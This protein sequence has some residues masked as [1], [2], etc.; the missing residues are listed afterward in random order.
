MSMM[1]TTPYGGYGVAPGQPGYGQ[2]VTVPQAL[3]MVPNLLQAMCARGQCTP[4]EAQ[5]VQMALQNYQSQ[6][7]FVGGVLHTFGNTQVNP[8]TIQDWVYQKLMNAVLTLRRDMGR[9]NMVPGNFQGMP[10]PSGFYNPGPQNAAPGVQNLAEV[11]G[12]S[13]DQNEGFQPVPP[14]ASPQFNQNP[15]N[16]TAPQDASAKVKVPEHVPTGQLH[17]I[18]LSDSNEIW[19]AAQY[20][21]AQPPKWVV[22]CFYNGGGAINEIE[23]PAH[24]EEGDV[25]ADNKIMSLSDYGKVTCS[26]VIVESCEISMKLPQNTTGSAMKEMEAVAPDLNN[27]KSKYAHCVDVAEIEVAEAPYDETTKLLDECLEIYLE[28][29]AA[30]GK[31]SLRGADKVLKHIG[32]GTSKSIV[33]VAS[34]LLKTF[35]NAAGVNFIKR[36]SQYNSVMR[37]E[38]FTSLARFSRLL[39]DTGE[40]KEWMPENDP[41]SFPMA[42]KN[43][44]M[45]SFG[46]IFRENSKPYLDLDKPENVQMLLSSGKVNIVVGDTPG[47]LINY[48]TANEETKAEVILQLKKFTPFLIEH[49]V[50]YHNLFLASDITDQIGRAYA[51]S[52][53]AESKILYKLFSKY[54]VLELISPNDPMSFSHPLILGVSYDNQ[55]LARRI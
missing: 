14:G 7:S 10:Q 24:R 12:Q 45:A 15:M 38:Q 9:V 28:P 41:T 11:Y 47:R 32:G 18:D 1:Y 16:P 6:Q 55:L 50:L 2:Q 17:E 43:C 39:S 44:I 29:D 46:R 35:N 19:P 49:K 48:E 51:I 26:N 23:Q 42:L 53:T 34:A 5:Q 4:A 31:R 52:G 54:G 21:R 8:N 20:T 13:I 22:D 40:F 27:P 30:T 36:I 37:L 33:A 3:G 25:F